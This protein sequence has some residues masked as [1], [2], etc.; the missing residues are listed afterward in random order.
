MKVSKDQIL[1]FVTA[2]FQV[3]FVGANTCFLAA[4]KFEHS[5]ITGFL[6]SLLWTLNVRRVA[7]GGW[8][9]RFIYAT[10]AGMGTVSGM[11]LANYIMN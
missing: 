6:I 4:G 11:T 9:D 3:L 10:G 2:Y 1:L 7:F 8:S 5:L